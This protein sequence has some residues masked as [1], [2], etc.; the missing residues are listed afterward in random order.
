MAYTVSIANQSVPINNG[1]TSSITPE[2]FKQILEFV[3][4]KDWVTQMDKAQRERGNEMDIRSI[5]I[6]SLDFFGSSKL[7]FIKFKTD[8]RFKENGKSAPGIVFMRG[9]SVSVLIILRCPEKVDQV[10]LTLQPRIP[11][12]SLGFPEL[13]A[14]MLDGSGNFA[15]TAAKE[16]FEETGLL[17]ENHEL[18][19]LTHE[20]YGDQ[21]PGIY[22]S[23][24]G[25]DEFVRLFMCIKE[26]QQSDIQAL[27]GKLTG[28]RDRG[29][30][31]ILKLVPLKDAWKIAPDAKLLSTLALY[32]ALKDTTPGLINK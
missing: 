23:A 15:G 1:T 30:N 31:I 14:G 18:T 7:G 21:W 27:E 17:I 4:F 12:G 6:Q 25:C 10:L 11:I 24:G 32:N 9:G 19:D 5:E 8:V 13:P 22:P 16:I 29:E 3:P 2:I 20:V 28:L 26:M